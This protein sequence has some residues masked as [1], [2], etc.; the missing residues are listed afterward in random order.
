MRARKSP[1]E[2]G[3]ARVKVVRGETLVKCEEAVLIAQVGSQAAA[4]SGQGRAAV[5]L[6]HL[7]RL[8]SRYE[9]EVKHRVKRRFLP[10]SK[11]MPARLEVRSDLLLWFDIGNQMDRARTIHGRRIPNKVFWLAHWT[12]Q[13]GARENEVILTPRMRKCRSTSTSSTDSSLSGTQQRKGLSAPIPMPGII[14]S[15]RYSSIKSLFDSS[16]TDALLEPM[17]VRAQRSASGGDLSQDGNL[18]EPVRRASSASVLAASAP[19]EEDEARLQSNQSEIPSPRASISYEFVCSSEQARDALIEAVTALHRPITLA[20]LK[21][22]AEIGK[23]H[24]GR[25]LMVGH[26]ESGIPMALKAMPIDRSRYDMLMTEKVVLERVSDIRCH[27]ITRLLFAFFENGTL[28]L[29]CELCP[30]GD[31]WALLQQKKRLP[32]PSVRFIAAEL[33]TALHCLHAEGIVHRDIKPENILLTAAG[34]VKVTDF[35]LAKFLSL[36]TSQLRKTRKQNVLD[37]IQAK[38]PASTRSSLSFWPS[39]SPKG[40]AENIPNV[41]SGSGRGRAKSANLEIKETANN[42]ASKRRVK[43]CV[44]GLSV[45]GL[46][47]HSL[48]RSLKVEDLVEG[49]YCMCERFPSYDRSFTICGTSFYMAPEMICGAGHGFALDW[50]QYGCVVYEL[51]G[52]HPAFYHHDSGIMEEKILRGNP[53]PFPYDVSLN[54]THD[55]KEFLSKLLSV[56]P[57]GRLGY[58]SSWDVCSHPFF[59]EI[60]WADIEHGRPPPTAMLSQYAYTSSS[61]P[62]KKK[63]D[64]SARKKMQEAHLKVQDDPS[65]V[66]PVPVPAEGHFVADPSSVQTEETKESPPSSLTDNDLSDEEDSLDEDEAFLQM[67]EMDFDENFGTGTTP[68]TEEDVSVLLGSFPGSSLTDSFAPL[69][70]ET[71]PLS[72]EHEKSSPVSD[73]GSPR[74]GTRRK[75]RSRKSRDEPFPAFAFR[76]PH[77]QVYQEAA[78]CAGF[79]FPPLQM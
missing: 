77:L 54:A 48:S 45:S 26:K 30:S 13:K 60:N 2:S 46:Q 22:V 68:N 21:P 38:S 39:S 18:V 74:K 64:R 51:L 76:N 67:E 63:Q 50:W 65:V 6:E 70:V 79:S 36:S 3:P 75:K 69:H 53:T 1:R 7:E 62:G 11:T 5:K 42:P 9:D 52:G 14:M 58:Q 71:V 59:G 57:R 10:M 34:H 61:S 78:E 17:G 32:E 28:Y 40:G 31:L 41:D 33:A 23:G 49:T 29:S 47:A 25:V 66:G 16:W 24:F 72:S 4:V 35:G 55:V 20:Q 15:R 73:G 8:V 19:N 56:D 37:D 44:C 43:K 27:A 12:L